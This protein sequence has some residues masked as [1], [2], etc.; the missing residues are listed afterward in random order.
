MGAEGA[1]RQR[2]GETNQ[3]SRH[4]LDVLDDARRP[5]EPELL[6]MDL[7]AE[8]KL[9]LLERSHRLGLL[10]QALPGT[11]GRRRDRVALLEDRVAL[12][13]GEGLG[14]REA[15]DLGSRAADASRIEALQYVNERVSLGETGGG[16]GCEMA[17]TTMSY[18]P[19]SSSS[20]ANRKVKL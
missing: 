14:G 2:V 4:P 16:G 15:L 8:L 9:G 20:R 12:E 19:S 11:V 1:L 7:L 6:A 10:E 5:H 17:L 18:L 3:D 13:D